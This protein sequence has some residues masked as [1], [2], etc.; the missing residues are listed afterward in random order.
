MGRVADVRGLIELDMP[1]RA[2]LPGFRTTDER[3]SANTTAR[4]LLAH[5]G[6]FEGDIWAP[7]TVGEDALQRFVEDL[8]SRA[9]QHAWPGRM[10]SYCSA[11][12]G[13]LGRLVE[14]LRHMSY[15]Q[16]LR[17]YLAGPLDVGGACLLRR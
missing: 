10:Y 2:Y 17:R 9:P 3:A 1:V 16:A 13:V 12:Y 4:H 15:P 11:G 6:G 14:V 8:V 7:T 5:T